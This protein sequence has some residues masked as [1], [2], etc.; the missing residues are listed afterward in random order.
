MFSKKTI[1]I[2]S[3]VIV[4]LLIFIGGIFVWQKYFVS[5]LVK[6]QPVANNNQEAMAASIAAGAQKTQDLINQAKQLAS[7]NKPDN[8]AQVITVKRTDVASGTVTEQAVVV[9]PHSNPISEK[10]GEVLTVDGSTV[11]KAGTRAGDSNAILQS[12]PIDSSKLPT[13]AIK[14]IMNPTSIIPAEFTVSVGQVV[15]LSATAAAS[16]MDI[17]KFDD[18]SLSAVAIGLMPH[19][20]LEITF[21]APTKPGEY[22]FYSDFANHRQYGAVGKMIVK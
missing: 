9:A 17:L 11:A 10:S 2:M 1:V 19:Q 5:V 20:T 15:V 12:A 16:S 18:P 21:N 6:N 14:L 13:D 22:T 3:A 4:V 7:V 8:I